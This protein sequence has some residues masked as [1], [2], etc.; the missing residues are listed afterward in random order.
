MFGGVAMGVG[1]MGVVMLVR[2]TRGV[3]LMVVGMLMDVLVG[4]LGRGSSGS[5]AF[6][7]FGM[8]F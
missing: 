2:G 5:R 6:S 1:P 8:R 4:V 3:V 7:R